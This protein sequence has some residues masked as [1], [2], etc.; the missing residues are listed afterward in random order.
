VAEYTGWS[1]LHQSDIKVDYTYHG[2]IVR[3]CDIEFNWGER[4]VTYN[5]ASTSLHKLENMLAKAEP[6]TTREKVVDVLKT[7]GLY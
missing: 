6:S 2:D 3:W 1:K 7:F 5:G 4:D